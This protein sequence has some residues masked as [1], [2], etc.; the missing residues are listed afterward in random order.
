MVAVLRGP[1][2]AALGLAHDR[3]R[4]RTVG[5]GRAQRGVA[6]RVTAPGP[7]G[8]RYQTSAQRGE[9][10]API[11][12]A[13]VGHL[14]RTPKPRSRPRCSGRT[15]TAASR[16]APRSPAAA[17]RRGSPT[18]AREQRHRRRRGRARA[19]RGRARRRA[20]RAALAHLFSR[21]PLV[22]FDGAV[23]EIDDATST[24]HWE[25]V[26]STN[27]QTLRRK[28]PPP[29]QDAIGWR[30]EFRPMEAQVTDFENAVFA[31][32]LAARARAATAP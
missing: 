32:R 14:T 3:R 30:V 28:P 2:R 25:N 20:G 9:T 29:G 19:A 5:V 11:D 16:R 10:A 15:S 13:P 4:E 18:V 1:R 17:S 8:A 12:R 31:C 23:G 7:R 21:D 26:Q 27:W 22:I 6:R 24:E